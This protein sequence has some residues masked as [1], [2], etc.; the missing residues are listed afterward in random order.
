MFYPKSGVLFNHPEGCLFR[1][2]NPELN[3]GLFSA[4]NLSLGL[5]HRIVRLTD[6][7]EGEN[8]PKE[9]VNKAPYTISSKGILLKIAF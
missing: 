3:A 7:H 5:S 2:K 6:R 1:C 9:W 8:M 4:V